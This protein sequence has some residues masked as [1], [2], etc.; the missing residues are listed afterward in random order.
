MKKKLG[1]ILV[2]LLLVLLG[3]FAATFTIYMFNLE[4]KLIYYVIRPFLNKH[5][6]SQKRDRRIV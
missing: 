6:D 3:A 5:Y 4:N 2:K 1:S